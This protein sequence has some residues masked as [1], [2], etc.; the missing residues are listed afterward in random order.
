MMTR[1]PEL[2]A[3]EGHTSTSVSRQGGSVTFLILEVPLTRS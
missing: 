2:S 3:G 1:A